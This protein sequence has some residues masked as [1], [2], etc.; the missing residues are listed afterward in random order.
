MIAAG[1]DG[2]FARLVL[3]SEY[4]NLPRPSLR[5]ES[6]PGHQARRARGI[7][8]GTVA[9]NSD[10]I[11]RPTRAGGS[12]RGSGQ[13][14]GPGCRARADSGAGADPTHAGE[15]TIALP[16]SID[17]ERV[18]HRAPAAA[19]RRAHRRDP[20]RPRLRRRRAGSPCRRGRDPARRV[21]RMTDVRALYVWMSGDDLGWAPRDSHLRVELADDGLGDRSRR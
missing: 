17:G 5:N 16:L 4:R 7:D 18:R 3:R 8:S 14:P 20:A 21:E 19:T 13:R 6:R 12:S 15:P 1:N 9:T 2:L 11:A 10:R